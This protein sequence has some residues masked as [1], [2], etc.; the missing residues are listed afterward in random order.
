M[1]RRPRLH[2]KNCIYHIYNRGNNKRN[3]FN[4]DKDYIKFLELVFEIADELQI[5]I[6]FYSLQPNHFHI[7]IFTY[8]DNISKYLQKLFQR[9]TQYFNLKYNN[10]GNLFQ[11]RCK[12]IIVFDNKYLVTLFNYIHLNCLKHNLSND[13]YKYEWSSLKYFLMIKCVPFENII[14]KKGIKMLMELWA[15]DSLDKFKNHILLLITNDKRNINDISLPEKV[16]SQFYGD[17]AKVKQYLK[18]NERRKK[19]KS[20]NVQRRWLDNNKK[21]SNQIVITKNI[22]SDECIVNNKILGKYNLNHA[23]IYLDRIINNINNINLANKFNTSISN[24]TQICKR[25]K[26]K[27]EKDSQ[28]QKII[29][30]II[31]KIKKFNY[32]NT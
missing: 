31:N 27:I 18:E 29:N 6:L 12:S 10:V 17:K 14:I 25:F 24:I 28:L 23:L 2:F 26:I 22:F 7:C 1:P 19:I 4:N 8:K 3:I 11:K 5:L 13:P 32:L 16:Y 9:Y 20:V 21:L 15:F 30:S